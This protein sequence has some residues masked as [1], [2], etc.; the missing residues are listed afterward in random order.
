MNI[1]NYNKG[2]ASVLFAMTFAIVLSL[3]AIGFATLVRND[4]REV[5][6]QTLGYQAQYA[7]EA[8]VNQVQANIAKDGALTPPVQPV[9]QD[10][11]FGNEVR[12]TCV[13]WTDISKTIKFSSVSED[14]GPKSFR[15]TTDGTGALN[16][17]TI[18]WKNDLADLPYSPGSQIL[19]ANIDNPLSTN[20]YKSI[21]K[22]VMMKSDRTA[23]SQFYLVPATSA[24]SSTD[25]NDGAVYRTI[26]AAGSECSVTLGNTSDYAEGYFAITTIGKMSETVTIEAVGTNFKGAQYTVD[27]TAIANDVT[28]RVEARINPESSTWRPNNA[29]SADK[30]CKDIRIDGNTNRKSVSTGVADSACPLN[31]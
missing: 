19:P 27:V 24:D 13:K 1:K 7:A 14:R 12:A 26:C 3:I 9:C 11:D 23:L 5:L 20:E 6:D 2:M 8:A 10:V 28:K 16:N 31:P 21:I 4:Q 17:L 30:I 29:I 25:V 15:L 22:I 18:R